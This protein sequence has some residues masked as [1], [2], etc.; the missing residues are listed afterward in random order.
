MLELLGAELLIL[1]GLLTFW[2][3]VGDARRSA[4]AP[5]T[6]PERGYPFVALAVLIVVIAS[7]VVSLGG[8]RL[9]AARARRS[10]R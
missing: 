1:A 3:R 8:T 9:A 7:P 5:L 6:P 10:R 4:R 2:P